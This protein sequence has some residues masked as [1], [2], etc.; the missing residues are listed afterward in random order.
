MNRNFTSFALI[1]WVVCYIISVSGVEAVGAAKAELAGKIF[2][3][4]FWVWIVCF[5]A[6][7]W[8]ELMKYGKEQKKDP[9]EGWR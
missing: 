2:G 3:V 5:G 6:I 4:F 7:V 1:I 9:L 8:Y